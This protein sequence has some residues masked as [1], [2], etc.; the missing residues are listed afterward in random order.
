MPDLVHTY[1]TS[2]IAVRRGFE[3]S[4][5]PTTNDVIVVID[6]IRAF[7]TACVLLDGGAAEIVCVRGRAEADG[8]AAGAIVVG[9]VEAGAAEAGTVPNSPAEVGRLDV[10]SRRVVLYTLNGTRQLCQ[11][12]ACWALMAAAAVNAE[13]TARWIRSNAS[14]RGVHL[15]V[16]DPENPEDDACARYLAD[17]LS[18][19]DAD[20]RALA[21]E[22]RA[23]RES[24]RRL[25]GSLVAPEVWQAFDADVEMCAQV[26]EYPFAMI[27]DV[28]SGPDPVIRGA[29]PWSRT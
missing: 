25:W 10:A 21:R 1:Q 5:P 6:A 29:E 3:L 19:R 15:L 11:A 2:G 12:P 9:E 16:S 26:N 17:L 28:D 18:G 14:G 23:A 8:V 24:H 20:A 7:T 4:A 27:V 13:A 22:V